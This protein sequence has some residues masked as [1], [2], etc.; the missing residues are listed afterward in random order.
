[1]KKPLR[2]QKLKSESGLF[3]YSSGEASEEIT[4]LSETQDRQQPVLLLRRVKKSLCFRNS[5]QPTQPLPL[6]LRRMKKSLCFQKLKTAN[7]ASSATPPANE[8]RN[9]SAFRNSRHHPL[10]P[11]LYNR[12]DPYNLQVKKFILTD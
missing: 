10:Q 7:T 9:R 5:R 12:V 4:P 3:R 2:F 11:R 8:E 6:L 1:M